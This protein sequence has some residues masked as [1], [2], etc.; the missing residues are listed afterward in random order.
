LRELSPRFTHEHHHKYFQEIDDA[1]R[2]RN[3][4]H[5]YH[6]T[7]R[8][9]LKKHIL[10]PGIE[11]YY[12]LRKGPLLEEKE[13]TADLT[14]VGSFFDGGFSNMIALAIFM[15]C[16]EIYLFGCG[17]T[18]SP[19]QAW[20]FH[21]CLLTTKDPRNFTDGE[22][23]DKIRNFYLS[24]P[25]GVYGS[26]ETKVIDRKDGSFL[27]DFSYYKN[28]TEGHSNDWYYT[29]RVIRQFAESC[30]TRIFNVVPQGYESPVYEKAVL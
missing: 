25:L 17:Y 1:F 28:S 29:H 16:K 6:A 3:T 27:I 7:I 5:F 23:E 9:Y 19:A 20:H 10:L 4:I 24:H 11:C 22:M 8:R 26:M 13:L 14:K 2:H 12:F 18:Y 30:G 21:N 15:G